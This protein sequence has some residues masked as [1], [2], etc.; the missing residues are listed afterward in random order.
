MYC[1][2]EMIKSLLHYKRSYNVEVTKKHVNWVFQ[3]LSIYLT[4]EY[5][6]FRVNFAYD[7]SKPRARTIYTNCDNTEVQHI[8]EHTQVPHRN[9]TN[10]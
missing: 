4:V 8:Y 7:V 10:F 6:N 5:M 2:G 3:D 9:P 1:I